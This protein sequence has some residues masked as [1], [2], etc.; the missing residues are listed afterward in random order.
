MKWLESL[1]EKQGA[2]AEELI[3]NPA[4]RVE[5]PP[6]W[7]ASNTDTPVDKPAAVPV[8]DQPTIVQKPAM[9]QDDPN[10]VPGPLS[11]VI[12]GPG[13]STSEQDDAMKWLESLA[14]KQGAKA[15][16]L[17]TDPGER[18]ES[19]PDWLGSSAA[20]AVEQPGVP[21][22]TDVPTLVQKP[23]A[24]EDANFMSGLGTSASEQ[25][26]AMKWLE[27]LTDTSPEPVIPPAASQELPAAQNDDTMTWLQD[28]AADEPV[29]QSPV[30]AVPDQP[31]SQAALGQMPW[32]QEET[33]SS[34]VE[35]LPWE[36]QTPPV[37]AQ[38][39]PE[40]ESQPG[41]DVSEWLK[42]LDVQDQDQPTSSPTPV[43]APADAMPDWLNPAPQGPASDDD[44]PDWLKDQSADEQPAAPVPATAWVPA[45]Q[46]TPPV[47][48][49]P[50]TPVADELPQLIFSPPLE[51]PAPPVETAPPVPAP[52]PAGIPA[53]TPTPTTP[54][55]PPMPLRPAVRQT[56]MLGDKDGPVLHMARQSM[57][58]G[59]LDAAINGY[60]KLIKRAKFLE[61]V[62]YD[63]KEATYTHPVDVIIWQTLGDAHM[64][65]NQLQ[66]ALDA[67]TKAEELLR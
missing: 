27:G 45:S 24:Q 16:E 65:N 18:T 53:S 52:P 33:P 37:A 32:E 60:T 61:E 35:E 1:A 42:N 20:S 9:A 63:L 4:D 12:S 49:P 39:A 8:P 46:A 66:E 38:N 13:T 57:E 67:Y 22:S 7:V 47:S 21:A 43:S 25:D 15:E 41:S 2:K 19:A 6:G 28:L 44:L 50:T 11:P 64:R 23:R 14:E 34:P 31:D 26:D 29:S 30:E 10:F 54:V 58:H 17:I 40:A 36:T 55:Q 56:G 5:N 62:I 59:G 48:E 51:R 3:T